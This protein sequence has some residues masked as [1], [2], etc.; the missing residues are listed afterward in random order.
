MEVNLI[1]LVSEYKGDEGK[2]RTYLEHCRW[3][4]G[5]KC[6]R[7][8]SPKTSKAAKDGHKFNCDVCHYQFTVTASTIFHDLT[9]LFGSGFLASIL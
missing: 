9:C 3:P 4:E 1:D 7:C 6:P 2:C 5:L 8:G